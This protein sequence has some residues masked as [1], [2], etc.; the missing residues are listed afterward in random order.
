MISMGILFGVFFLALFIGVPIV[1]SLALAALALLWQMDIMVPELIV[2]RMFDG[3]DSF[4]M[5]AIPFFMLAG[6]LMDTGGISI[7]LVRFSNVLVGWISGGLAHVAVMAS[8]FFA[9]ISGSAVADTTAIGSTLI[10]IMKR[11]NFDPDFSAS[12]VAAAGVIGPIIPPSIPMVLYGVIAGQSIGQLFMAGIV[13]GLI[14]GLGLMIMIY[15]FAKKRNYPCEKVDLSFGTLLRTTVEASGALVMPIII[16]GGILGGIF[17]AT[18]AAVVAV[19]YAFLIGMFVYREL[20]WKGMPE[21]IFRAGL[22]TGM[23]L[24]IV[25]VANLIG[26][27]LAAEQIPLAL[28]MWFQET[29]SSQAVVL[30]IINIA[31]LFVGC[32][33]DGGSAMIIFAPVLLP[34]ILQFGIDPVFFGVLMTVNLMIGTVTPPVG[35]SLYIAGGIAKISLE[36]IS[37]A[38]AP[39]LLLEVAVLLLITYVPDLVLF[40]PRLL[41]N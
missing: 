21:I 20:T 40:L 19:V 13:P 37:R 17:T 8:I 23:I 31:L 30:L 18:E 32:F 33:I 27:I 36:Q 25:G 28:S 39:F 7:R 11:R 29:I 10:P 5:M 4:P 1:F 26:F 16:V 3:I 9:G 6:A 38:I 12:V 35:L 41:W 15:F 34:V 2:Q 22:S 14:M 24:I